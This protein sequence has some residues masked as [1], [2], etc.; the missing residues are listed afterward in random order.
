MQER[1]GLRGIYLYLVCLVTLVMLIFGV[2]GLARNVVE[3]AYPQPREVLTPIAL[4]GTGTGYDAEEWAQQQEVQRQWERRSAVLGLVGNAAL[5]LVAG[6]LY[7]YHWR[8][9]E[10][11][12]ADSR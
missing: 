9:V 10:Q 3:V 1:W 11:G 6:P 7:R 8:K 12:R 4:S 5:V 2:S